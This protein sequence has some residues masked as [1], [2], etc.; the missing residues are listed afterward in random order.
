MGKRFENLKPSFETMEAINDSVDIGSDSEGDL[1]VILDR[2]IT[3]GTIRDTLGDLDGSAIK[4][5]AISKNLRGRVTEQMIIKRLLSQPGD[6]S[7]DPYSGAYLQQY[8]GEKMN[9]NTLSAIKNTILRT[10]T[11]DGFIRTENLIVEVIPVTKHVINIILLIKKRFA[12]KHL[13]YSFGFY[14][15]EQSTITKW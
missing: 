8:V 6:W 12:G 1:I 13:M 3:D 2:D 5:V 4:D 14:L 7:E 15:N 11:Y 9:K 10:L